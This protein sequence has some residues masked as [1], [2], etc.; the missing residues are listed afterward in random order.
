[1][2]ASNRKERNGPPLSVTIVTSGTTLPCSSLG[3]VGQRPPGQALSLG[4]GERDPGDRVVLV[5][6]GALRASPARIRPV[7]PAAG[8]PPRAAGGVLELGE[9]QLP[10]LV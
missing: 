2:N 7:V 9:V 6:R 8:Q 1:M 4:E 10:H 3:Q 5:G